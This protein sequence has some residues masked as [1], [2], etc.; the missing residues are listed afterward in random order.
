MKRLDISKIEDPIG[1]VVTHCDWGGI[2]TITS[3]ANGVTNVEQRRGSHWSHAPTVG[4]QG[5]LGVSIWSPDDEFNSTSECGVTI[6][7]TEEEALALYQQKVEQY[8]NHKLWDYVLVEI[9]D[10]CYPL[11]DGTWAVYDNLVGTSY[12]VCEGTKLWGQ[13]FEAGGSLHVYEPD[14]GAW[15][16]WSGCLPT[17]RAA[18]ETVLKGLAYAYKKGDIVECGGADSAV[19][20]EEILKESQAHLSSLLFA[21]KDPRSMQIKAQIDAAIAADPLAFLATNP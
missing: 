2:W 13:V 20:I 15:V 16:D 7:K 18:E 1:M 4:F 19:A 12:F 14:K 11:E 21:A 6:C 17:T 5:I 3:S 8:R 10:G 9:V